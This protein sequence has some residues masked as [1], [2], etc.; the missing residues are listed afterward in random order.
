MGAPGRVHSAVMEL[1]L[2]HMVHGGACLARLGD[3]RLALVRGGIPGETVRADLSLRAGVM[4]GTV[5]EVLSASPARVEGT[6]HPGLDLDHVA[7]PHQLKLKQA[8]VADALGR[9]VRGE[10]T[11]PEPAAV[12]ASPREWG[13]RNTV[14]PAVA[15]ERLGY[16]LPASHQVRPLEEDPAAL[17]GIRKAWESLVAAGIPKGLREVVF[18]GN[19]AGEVLVALIAQASARNYL[20]WAH[21]LVRQGI[22]GVSHASYDPRGRFRKGSERI[23]GKRQIRQRYG[24]F[25]LSVTA[26]SFAQ[27]NPAAASLLYLRLR[28][29]AGSGAVAHDLYAGSGGISFHLAEHF[30]SVTAF[31]IDRTSV[32][33]GRNDAGRLGL[34]NVSF[35]GGDVKSSGFGAGADLITVDPPRGGLGA[36]VREDISLSDAGRLLYVSCDAATWARDVADFLERGWSLTL[37]EPYDF[38]PHTHHV[39]LLSLLER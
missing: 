11:V 25:E 32:Q 36:P 7:Y 30:G 14:Q 18:R 4:Q 20:D 39:E 3:G 22:T 35:R 1:V 24:N 12:V 10:R 13:Y 26:E 31:E 21:G 23:A 16:R 38:Y 19:D 33:R 15:G 37:V 29:L 6:D 17:P 2:Q 5:T 9:A 27:P 8:I 34:A 28:E